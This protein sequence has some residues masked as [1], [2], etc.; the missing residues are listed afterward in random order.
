[1]AVEAKTRRA[2]VLPCLQHPIVL[3][4]VPTNVGEERA[5]LTVTAMKAISQR[6]SLVT[7]CVRRSGVEDSIRGNTSAGRNCYDVRGVHAHFPF[8]AL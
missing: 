3:Q 4:G 1:M 6:V 8:F 2:R 5:I 7:R